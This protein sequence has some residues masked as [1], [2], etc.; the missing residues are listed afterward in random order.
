MH[1]YNI[2]GCGPLSL[3]RWH[4]LRDG[5]KW[6]ENLLPR[7]MNYCCLPKKKKKKNN[8]QPSYVYA[9]V[10]VIAKCVEIKC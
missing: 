4:S 8:E 6:C 9:V 3:A 10:H 1:M 5:S 2:T 7:R